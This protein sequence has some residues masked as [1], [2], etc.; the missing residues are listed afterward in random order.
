MPE[1]PGAETSTRA[2]LVA[3]AEPKVMVA[4]LESITV[5]ELTGIWAPVA[6][7]V[8]TTMRSGVPR[9]WVIV[10]LVAEPLPT[11]VV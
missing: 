6:T 3:G 5:T 4:E 8:A 10:K 7:L 1:D 11:R 9:L 2:L